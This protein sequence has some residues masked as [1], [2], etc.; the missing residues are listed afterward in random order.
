MQIPLLDELDLRRPVK[1]A[2]FCHANVK[3][4]WDG[5]FREA[6]DASSAIRGLDYRRVGLPDQS[7][8]SMQD[9]PPNVDFKNLV[10][11]PVPLSFCSSQNDGVLRSVF[12]RLFNQ[13]FFSAHLRSFFSTD[14]YFQPRLV[15][16]RP[17]INKAPFVR[18]WLNSTPKISTAIRRRLHKTQQ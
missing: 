15:Q 9:V 6:G 2:F 12:F 4:F 14:P 13:H 17:A 3:L 7:N 11:C 1:E 18:P 10:R 5:A 8:V 16:P